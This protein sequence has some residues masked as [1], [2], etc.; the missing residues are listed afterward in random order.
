MRSLTVLVLLLIFA[1][2]LVAQPMLET[3]GREMPNEWID[4]VTQH[5]IVKLVRRPGINLS[6][7]FHNNPFVGNK[8]V[9]YGSDEYQKENYPGERNKRAQEIYNLNVKNKQLYMVDLKTLDVQQLSHRNGPV[10]GEIVHNN[11]GKV[12]YQSN[13]SVFSIDINTRKEQ[14]VFVFPE[15][16]KGNIT[17]VNADGT[18]LGGAHATDAEKEISR[19][20]PEKSQFF[21]RIYEA[22]LPRTLFTINIANGEL[23]KVFTDSAWLNHV[24]FS[25]T[26]PHLLMFCHEGPWHKVDRIWTIDV[27]KR[28]QPTLIHKRTMAMEIAGHEWFSSDG[29]YIWYDLQL[30]RGETFYVGGTNLQTG[31]EVK[32]Q[33]TQNEWSVHYTTSPDQSKFAGDGGDPG[34]V[35]KA[36]DGQY[37]Y[38]FIPDNGHFKSRK[39]VN[40]KNHNYKLEP[41]VH[42]SPDGKWIIFRANFEG[43]EGIYAVE[44]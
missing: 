8:M 17:T 9:F 25:P 21:N 4:D 18:L 10:A 43:F 30:P 6:F 23:Q 20:Y 34:A 12:Y 19:K 2:E 35:A 22:K 26:D 33:L 13:D 39:L 37:I 29:Q 14:L 24:Q 31:K 40:M 27:L 44:I 42:Y 16:F 11:T 1:R 38:E 28:A 32:Y 3:G 36:P 7:Y 41:N 5:R 15:D